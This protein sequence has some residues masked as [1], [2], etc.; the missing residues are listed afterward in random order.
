MA[1][2][3]LR[4]HDL[5]V[6]SVIL[7]KDYAYQGVPLSSGNQLKVNVTVANKGTVSETFHVN[8]TAKTVL[9]SYHSL[10]YVDSNGNSVYDPGEVVVVDSDG[11]GLYGSGTVDCYVGFIVYNL[12]GSW[13]SGEVMVYDFIVDV[14]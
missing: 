4:S 10:K 11:N 5:I 12:E 9:T 13:V 1:V 7:S 8:A 3:V 6:Q 2:T 14:C